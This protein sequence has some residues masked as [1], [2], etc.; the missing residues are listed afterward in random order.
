MLNESMRNLE[1]SGR[2]DSEASIKQSEEIHIWCMEALRKGSCIGQGV[3]EGLV[4]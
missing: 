1:Y 3:C 4:S 2:M